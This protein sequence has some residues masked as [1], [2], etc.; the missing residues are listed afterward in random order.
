MREEKKIVV[1]IPTCSSERIPL[2][3]QTVE[4]IQAGSYKNV[5]PVIIADGNQHIYEVAWK[6]LHNVS[7]TMNKTRIDWVA[8]MNRA[9]RQWDS[10]FYIFASDDL[11]FPRDCIKH[12]IATMQRRFSDGFGVVAI[13]K[14]TRCTFGLLGRKLVDHFPERQVF[15]PDYVHFCSDPELM[16]MAKRLKIFAVPPERESQVKHF[17]NKDETWRLARAN[18]DRDREIHAERQEK[19]YLWGID[20]NLMTRR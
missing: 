20:F 7:I 16:N 19:G 5:H 13:G 6:K 10:E 14:K 2:L 8:S 17:R 3:I 12:A 15:C 18:R 4:S 9:L 11:I 1:I